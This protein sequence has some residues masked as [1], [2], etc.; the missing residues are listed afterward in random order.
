MDKI[1]FL[2]LYKSL[3]RPHLEYGSQAWSVIYKK[4]SVVLENVQRRATKLIKGICE[5]TYTQRLKDLGL[6]ITTIQKSASRHGAGLQD[7]QQHRPSRQ[8]QNNPNYSNQDQ[9]AQIQNIQATST[10]RHQEVFIQSTS[11]EQLE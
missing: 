2:Q 1:M 7:Y 3:V 8:R 4:E 11:G 9:R 10:T 5:K 6:S